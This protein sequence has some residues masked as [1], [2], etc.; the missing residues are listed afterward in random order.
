MP[1]LAFKNPPSSAWLMLACIFLL[2]GCSGIQLDDVS[3]SGKSFTG[4]WV[5]DFADSDEVPDLRNRV[6]K[7]KARLPGLGGQTN[8]SIRRPGGGSEL[9]FVVHDFQV[10]G[11]DKMEI[12]QGAQSMGIR[13][14]PGVYRDVSWGERQR[15]LWEVVSGWEDDTLIIFSR[16]GSMQV[17]EAFTGSA[18]RLSVVVTIEADDETFKYRRAFNRQG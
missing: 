5:L 1:S 3:P 4:V 15:G 2:T 11:A 10:L 13:Y 9:S 7:Q 6:A 17:H 16:A 8:R 12:E 18:N 14:F